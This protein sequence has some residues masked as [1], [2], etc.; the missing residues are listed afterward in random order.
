VNERKEMIGGEDYDSRDPA[1]VA[2]RFEA[3]RLTA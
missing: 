1:L 3:R 2:A